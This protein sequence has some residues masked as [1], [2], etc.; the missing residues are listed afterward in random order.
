MMPLIRP[1]RVE[2]RH[3]VVVGRDEY[4]N[5]VADWR[6]SEADVYMSAE[7]ATATEDGSVGRARWTLVAGPEVRLERGDRVEWGGRAYVVVVDPL[8]P[9]DLFTGAATHV[10]AT[11]EE[12]S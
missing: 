1:H 12:A 8:V 11:V 7:R 2:V 3:R 5:E 9:Q 6:V 10:E 4:G